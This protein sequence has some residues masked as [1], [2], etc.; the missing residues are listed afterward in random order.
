MLKR[1]MRLLRAKEFIKVIKGEDIE[2]RIKPYAIHVK[3]PVLIDGIKSKCSLNFTSLKFDS[4]EIK[5]SNFDGAINFSGL[6][7]NHLSLC[8]SSVS[9]LSF[10]ESTIASVTIESNS[11]IGEL[12]LDKTSINDL[13]I[14]KIKNFN[15]VHLGCQNNVMKADFN[16][17]GIGNTELAPSSIY[18][19]PE[20]FGKIEINQICASAVEIGTFGK[21]AVL[22]A[23]GVFTD[24]FKI[25]NCDNSKSQVVL[26]NIKPLSAKGSHLTIEDSVLDA[27]V[28]DVAEM[29]KFGELSVENSQVGSLTAAM[30]EL[31]KLHKARFWKRNISSLFLW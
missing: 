17:I 15:N 2:F 30:T 21:H 1:E 20:Q 12:Y 31:K 19:C 16:Y 9:S 14:S 23:D 5:N 13:Q 25:K 6:E 18:I 24:D 11:Y 3:E 22:K 29:K 28:M 7:G 8:N 26:K 10:L 27:T 4:I